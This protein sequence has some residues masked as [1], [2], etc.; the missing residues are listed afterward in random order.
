MGSGGVDFY[1]DHFAFGDEGGFGFEDFEIPVDV[2]F[3][4][5]EIPNCTS[6]LSWDRRGLR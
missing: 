6:N 1:A 4:I 5:L 2:K 3:M